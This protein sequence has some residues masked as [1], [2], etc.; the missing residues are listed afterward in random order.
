MMV[1]YVRRALSLIASIAFVMA[2]APTQAAGQQGSI[3][4]RVVDASSRNPIARAQVSLVGT[5]RGVATAEDGRFQITN[6]Q[7]GVYQVRVLRI[8]YQSSTQSVTVGAGA[9]APLEF[10]LSAVAV[11]LDEVVTTATGET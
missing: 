10:A 9:A 11:K 8:G 5:T 6:L 4:G 2:I 1:R 3:T 7:P